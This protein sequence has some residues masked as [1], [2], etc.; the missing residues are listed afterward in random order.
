MGRTIIV[1]LCCLVVCACCFPMPY[2][3]CPNWEVW[4]VNESGAPQIGMTVRLSYQDYSREREGQQEDAITDSRGLAKRSA[5]ASLA[6]RF[7]G[8]LRSAAAGGVHAS[9]GRHGFRVCVR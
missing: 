5:S 6:Q 8:V 7:F 1:A 4:V 9:F 3:V 2:V